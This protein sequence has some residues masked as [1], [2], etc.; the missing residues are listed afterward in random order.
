MSIRNIWSLQPGEC[1][2][3][4]ELAK[5]GFEVYFPLHDIGIDLLVVKGGRHVGIQVKESRYYNSRRWKSG[6]VGHSWHQI[7]MKKLLKS[8]V[9]FYIFLTYLAVHGEH[10]V[11]RFQNRFL[12]VPRSDLE[13]RVVVKDAGKKDVFSFCFHFEGNRVWDER[14]KISLEDKRTDYSQF[15][16]AWNLIEQALQ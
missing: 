5:R 3:A 13:K 8:R 10:K 15:L 14:V 9:D 12:I 6:H 11:S 4:E 7:Q 1:F 2:L 16:E